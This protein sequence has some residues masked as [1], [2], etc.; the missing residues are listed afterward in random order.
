ME[1]WLRLGCAAQTMLLQALRASSFALAAA[2]LFPHFR[3]SLLFFPPDF[4]VFLCGFWRASWLWVIQTVTADCGHARLGRPS[5]EVGSC[6]WRARREPSEGRVW[7]LSPVGV[8]SQVR[9]WVLRGSDE[10]LRGFLGAVGL[11]VP[12][13][14]LGVLAHPPAISQ[15][16]GLPFTTHHAPYGFH[17]GACIPVA[18]SCLLYVMGDT[19]SQV[20]PQ[21]CGW[22]RDTQAGQRLPT[23]GQ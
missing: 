18:P 17:S 4:G 12:R 15:A 6:S 1:I 21:E 14:G 22:F 2:P 13:K 23:L 8:H 16:S 9:V 5:S 7:G 11:Y 20:T 10:G 3:P 19:P